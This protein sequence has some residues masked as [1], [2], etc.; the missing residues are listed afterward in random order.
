M[1]CLDFR[2]TTLLALCWFGSGKS[3]RRRGTCDGK[4]I[5]HPRV[6]DLNLTEGSLP[7][8]LPSFGGYSLENLTSPL[9]VSVASPFGFKEKKRITM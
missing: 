5:I 9:L 4:L 2:N 1:L 8:K 6:R 7:A 3:S